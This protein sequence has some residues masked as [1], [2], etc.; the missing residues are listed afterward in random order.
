MQKYYTDA[1]ADS[2][3]TQQS[4]TRNPKTTW[5]DVLMLGTGCSSQPL[6]MPLSLRNTL[7]WVT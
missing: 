2:L 5:R 4:H 6:Q 3:P 1:L 7:R